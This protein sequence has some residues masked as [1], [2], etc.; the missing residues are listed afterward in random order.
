MPGVVRQILWFA[1]AYTVVILVHEAS[2]AVVA[3]AAGLDVTMFHFWVDID[4]D[5][6]A[7]LAQRAAFGLAGPVA[8]LV[9]GIAALIAYRIAYASA[10]AL[11]LLYVVIF[12]ISN[13]FGNMMSTAFIGDFSNVAAW[14]G[15]PMTVR[16]ALSGLGAVL[17]VCVL[18]RAGRELARW[19]SP[20][21]DR[22]SATITGVIGP[23]LVGTMLIVV[24]NQPVPIAGFTAARAG[25]AAMWAFAAAGLFTAR[26]GESGTAHHLRVRWQDVAIAAV[27]VGLVRVITR[28]I[29]LG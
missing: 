15:L 23:A 29:P 28:G 27:V 4:A 17:T 1:I 7:T 12:G 18:F 6:R 13:F 19:R 14:L 11:P 5:N 3:R 8:S 26:R 9:L 2:H 24:I 25:E 21:A 20:W 16:Y 22:L 10:A